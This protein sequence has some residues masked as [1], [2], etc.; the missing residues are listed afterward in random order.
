MKKKTL[1]IVLAA[2]MALSLAACGTSVSS[3]GSEETATSQTEDTSVAADTTQESTEEA[4][5]TVS[6]SGTAQTETNAQT[7]GGLLTSDGVYVGT[8][9]LPNEGEEDIT[10]NVY[11]LSISG[12]LMTLSGELGYNANGEEAYGD[13]TQSYSSGNYSF[14][15]SSDVSYE[16]RGGEE[17]QSMTQDEFIAAYQDLQDSGVALIIK[18]ENGVVTSLAI[19][20]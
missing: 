13:N 3:S 4:A 16:Q 1:T 10:G 19:T 5:A 9:Y 15:L 18:V 11:D 14:N 20:A 12:S 2:M 17:D 8:L 7:E 6:E